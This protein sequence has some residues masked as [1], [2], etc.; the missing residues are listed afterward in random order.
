M[1]SMIG[2]DIGH[3]FKNLQVFNLKGRAVLG[4]S[5][6]RRF[7]A[8]QKYSYEKKIAA[9]LHI[10]YEDQVK[11]LAKY[12][13]NFPSNTDFYITTT[14]E[15]TKKLIEKT[16]SESG[17]KIIC[18]IRP[19]IGVAMSTLWVTYADVIASGEYEYIC[20]IHDKKSPYS[21]YEIVG[22]QFAERC[23]ENLVGTKNVIENVIN[24]FENNPK[25]GILGPPEPYHGAYYTVFA[26][27]WMANYQNAVK[28][29]KELGLSVD[30]RAEIPPAAPLG[31]MF[32]F[33]A[34]ALKKIPE[35]NFK[36]EDFDVKYAP[37]GTK[38]HA[39]ERLY[40]YIA[41]DAGYYYAEVIN[42]DEARS[43]LVNFRY[44]IHDIMR[45]M[46]SAG[47]IAY[48]FELAK[49]FASNCNGTKQSKRL[50]LKSKVK[51]FIPTSVWKILKK[52]YHFF[53]GKKWIG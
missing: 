34:D 39:I 37:D 28:V 31:D 9:I 3:I 49:T 6:I 12:C 21:D 8:R 17:I 22:Q 26:D 14:C 16:F 18:T 15:K 29:A 35:M 20:Y 11:L 36:Y 47:C 53:G 41:Q 24:L 51:K 40:G 42:S 25:L 48:N 19:N 2:H 52:I 44:I 30:I 7:K 38:L 43:D 1:V 27:S 33:R 5:F 4:F 32:W 46:L 10:Y 45:N 50:V 13:N 23:F